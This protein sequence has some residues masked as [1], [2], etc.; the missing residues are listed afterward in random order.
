MF[1]HQE[2]SIAFRGLV[3]AAF[4][5]SLAGCGGSG[6]A[7]SSGGSAGA[8]SS[9][10]TSSSPATSSAPSTS[11][12]PVTTPALAAVP[13]N[14]AAT[15][16][17][18]EINLTWTAS[19]GATSYNIKRATVTGGPY[20]QLAS[21]S[22]TSY[23]DTSVTNGTQYFYV[24][25]ALDSAGES[26]NSAQVSA[27]PVAAMA[28]I[29][30][31]PTGVVAAA[32][33]AQVSLT[34]SSSTGATSYHIKRSTTSGGPYT[35]VSAPSSAAFIDTSLTNGTT[36]YYVVSALDSAGESG[37]STAVSATPMAATT[38]S[39][40]S[41]CG[42]QLGTSPV[43]FC[44]TFDAPA[45]IGNRAGD[46]N[47]NVWAVSR[48]IGGGVNFGQNEYN[49]W[50]STQIQK[51]DGTTP[52][53]T[54]PNDIIICNGQ[55][56]EASNDNN[57]G[58]FDAGDVTSLA[59]YPKQ[60][61]DYAGR[62]GTVSFDVSNDTTGTHAAWP[63][64]WMSD[65][66]VPDPFN[67]FDSWQ[68]LPANG[69]GVRFAA[70]APPGNPGTCQNSNNMSNWRWTVDSV[71]VVRNYVFDDTNGYGTGQVSLTPLDC[72]IASSGPGQMNHIEV[73]I[74]QNQINVYAT[75]AGVAP[76][77]T[78]LRHIATITNANLTLTR[79]LIWLEDVH[80]NADK[81]TTLNGGASEREHTFSWD[82]VAFDGPFTARDFSYDALDN[83]A[84]GLNGSVNLGK[85]SQANQTSSWNVL[86]MPANPQAAA[87]RV[88]FNFNGGDNPN[89]TVL[90]VIVNGNAHAVPWPYPDQLQNTW[91]TLAVTIPITD[92]VPG[93]NVL[94]LGADTAE[95]FS[96]I[97][98][99]LGD[100]PGGVPVLPGANDSYP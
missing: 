39:T 9:T 19:S 49:Q 7:A 74:S 90:N 63:E 50:N 26:A 31:T 52:Q 5:I 35:Q 55:L 11:S 43:I 32:G 36:Y 75:D 47:G 72:V 27:T 29:P 22:S 40:G 67:H 54:P 14:L 80:Y 99:V 91:R 61:F 41:E 62:T 83:T 51:C 12:A 46:L 77:P 56:R 45:G 93:T 42:M 84:P 25:S 4:G 48:A 71:V 95:V 82:N 38:S 73:R 28:A 100:V 6:G 34:W 17:S 70:A 98:I 94:Q 64:F 21:A 33:N 96:N 89:P 1:R 15:A 85:F 66:P 23:S 3:L 81:E 59:M 8:S 60:P 18:A 58:V 76:S 30:P 37:N 44:D 16:G 69:F 10:V 2:N 87:A 65:T 57:S 53:V 92:L 68:D 13:T 24:V 20:T 97:D 88:L 78:T 86:N 79:G